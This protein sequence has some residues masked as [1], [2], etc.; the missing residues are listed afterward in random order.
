[1]FSVRQKREIADAVQRIL[2]ETQH[3]EL[4]EGEIQFALHVSGSTP[5]SWADILNN[6]AVTAPTSNPWNEAQDGK[7]ETPAGDPL[8]K[9]LIAANTLCIAYERVLFMCQRACTTGSIMPIQ[10]LDIDH[11]KPVDDYRKARK[12]V[13]N[14]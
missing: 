2:R 5:M 4:P 14:P 6:G 1:M 10:G 13:F 7:P 11:S 3:P 8:R 12:A 9:L